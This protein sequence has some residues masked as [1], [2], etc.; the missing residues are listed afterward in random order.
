[1]EKIAH[2]ILLIHTVSQPEIRYG[3][4]QK[5]SGRTAPLGL[6]C[7]AASF[8]GRVAWVDMQTSQPD[9]IDADLVDIGRL[10]AVVVQAASDWT[11]ETSATFSNAL[12]QLFPHSLKILGGEVRHRFVRDWDIAFSGTGLTI[13]REIL[14]GKGGGKKGEAKLFSTLT[15][16]LSEPLRVPLEPLPQN[17]GYSASVE[18]CMEGPTIS[19][20]QPWLGILDRTR[21]QKTPPPA[22]FL[23]A[24][25]PWLKRCGFACASFDSMFFS[26]RH[27]CNLQEACALN[28][29]PFSLSLDNPGAI[30]KIAEFPQGFLSRIWL[31]PVPSAD[32]MDAFAQTAS[33]FSEI[34]ASFGLR[35]VPEA[36][37]DPELCGLGPI[38]DELS[39]ENPENWD[40]KLLRRTLVDFYLRQRNLWKRVFGLRSARDL[41]NLLRGAYGIFDLLIRR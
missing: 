38:C 26:E 22:G 5:A 20:Y 3:R 35:L 40:S 9:S 34:E 7:L 16:D 19:V 11:E 27:Y 18:K 24:L 4:L 15:E 39:I 25:I 41:L 17:I 31:K 1:M 8:P 12:A 10:K 14:A 37:G 23:V 36:A 6:A 2:E 32:S 13:L 29:M 30:C 28:R 21:K 33:R